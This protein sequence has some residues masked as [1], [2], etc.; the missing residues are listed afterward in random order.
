MTCWTITVLTLTWF[1][2]TVNVLMPQ[3]VCI[4]TRS[5]PA[6]VTHIG[7]GACVRHWLHKKARTLVDIFLIPLR[8]SGVLPSV[9]NPVLDQM[10]ALAEALL[11][12]TTFIRFL[13]SLDVILLALV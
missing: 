12:L 7:F 8:H 6:L 2:F 9:K 5:L 1:F 4:L 10:V 3:A 11:T 13:P